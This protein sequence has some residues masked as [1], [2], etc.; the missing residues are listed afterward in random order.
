MAPQQTLFYKS[1]QVSGYSPAINFEAKVPVMCL[2]NISYW[3]QNCV[4][5]WIID[6]VLSTATYSIDPNHVY[7]FL[8]FFY[9]PLPSE[10][11]LKI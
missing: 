10:R 9:T 6:F 11:S 8:F 5:S 4:F 2:N 7:T 1:F 3:E